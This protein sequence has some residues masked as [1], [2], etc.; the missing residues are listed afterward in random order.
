[1][2]HKRTKPESKGAINN[3]LNNYTTHEDFIAQQDRASHYTV[4]QF[5]FDMVYYI[6]ILKSSVH[7]S[8]Y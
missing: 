8:L 6:H 2:Q 5:H 4:H 3:K 1:M 7:T